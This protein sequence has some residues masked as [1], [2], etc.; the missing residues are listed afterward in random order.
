M[1]RGLK[2]G[3]TPHIQRDSNL[4]LQSGVPELS[5]QSVTLLPF[6]TILFKITSVL[7]FAISCKHLRY[8]SAGKNFFFCAS[9][10]R[11]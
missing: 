8:T 6:S 4:T 10:C 7:I 5:S 2:T 3:L 9:F 1:S 11:K